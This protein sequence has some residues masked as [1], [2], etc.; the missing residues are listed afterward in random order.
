MDLDRQAENSQHGEFPLAQ[1]WSVFLYNYRLL[2]QHLNKKK[3]KNHI[4]SDTNRKVL[5]FMEEVICARV[6]IGLVKA[7]LAQT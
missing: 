5:S 4:I 6:A 1:L 7:C 2:L 3:A